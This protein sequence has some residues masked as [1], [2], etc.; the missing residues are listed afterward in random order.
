MQITDVKTTA[1]V[2]PHDR[3]ARN[4]T[5]ILA[6]RD[7]L[8]AEVLTDEGVTGVGYIT[9]T[10][11]A[12]G[13]E[14][15]VIKEIVDRA[16]VDMVKGEDPFCV[17]KLWDR[18]FRLTRRYGRKGAAIRAMSVVDIALWDLMGKA[19][20]KPLYK[21]LGGFRDEV[22]VYGAGLYY[23][24]GQGVD[25]LV[26]HLMTY[27]D[28]GIHDVKLKVG[29]M[30]F[31]EDTERVKAV[32]EAI[33]PNGKLML[34]ANQAYDPGAAIKAARLWEQYDIAW[35]EEP[36][37]ADNIAGYVK[38]A[39][40][41]SIPIAGGEEEYTRWGFTDL[42]TN[43]ALGVCQA[44]AGRC[45]G[46]TEWMKIAA[47]ASAWN[48]PMAPHSVPEIGAHLVGAVSNGMV[49]EW[50]YPNHM[51]QQLMTEL[52]EEPL[53]V[54]DARNGTVKVPQSP[55]LGLKLNEK[56]IAKYKAS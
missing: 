18:M 11:A 52:F 51:S 4:A 26:R 55:G 43:G 17:E 14:I 15:F 47:M 3:V 10:G 38:V 45:G 36:V 21:L 28:M 39:N 50:Y 30:S 42:I 27:V 31:T 44:D 40:A 2:R 1:L 20:G 49:V 25:G 46:I 34:D 32:R 16:L 29:G 13:S 48:I 54:K 53:E 9:G 22:P 12:L 6:S 37:P 5:R 33:G 19:T 56:T 7:V 41:I 23:I 35:F 8:L 24:E